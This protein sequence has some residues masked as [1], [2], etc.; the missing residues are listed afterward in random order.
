MEERKSMQ[1]S[2]DAHDDEIAAKTQD[3]QTLHE[4]LAMLEQQF[5]TAQASIAAVTALLTAKE[6]EVY[7]C[8]LIFYPS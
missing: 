7:H 4:R 2:I 6:L 5:F 8:H 1:S 3:L